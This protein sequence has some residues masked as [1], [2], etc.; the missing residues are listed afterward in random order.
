MRLPQTQQGFGEDIGAFREPFEVLGGVLDG[1]HVT[2]LE[3]EQIFDE[4]EKRKRSESSRGDVVSLSSS[5]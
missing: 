2:R 3:E 1:A 5:F 4:K